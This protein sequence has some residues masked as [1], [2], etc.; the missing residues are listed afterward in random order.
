MADRPNIL[1]LFSDQQ[2]WDTLGCYGQRLPISPNL[3]ALAADGVRFEHAFTCQPVCGPARSCVQ[4]GK[5][6]TQV[7]C[8]ING[9]MLPTDIPTMAKQLNA[10]GYETA[11]I[12]K[13]HLATAPEDHGPDGQT[14]Y[15]HEGVPVER[16]GGYRDYWMASDV[17]EFT[18][19]GFAGYYFDADNQRVDWEGYR[20]DRTADF[21]L[22]YLQQHHERNAEQPDGKPFFCMAS[23]IEPHH[24]ND[25]NRHV[26]P[27]GSKDR[28]ADFDVPGDLVGM[29]EEGYEPGTKPDWPGEYPDYLGCCWSLDQNVGRIVEKLKA[30]GQ[31]ENTLIIYTSDHG[32][33][34]CTRNGEYKRSCH[35]ASI[36]LPMIMH[37]PASMGLRSGQVVDAL[38]SLIDVP[39][40]VLDAAGA[41]PIEG[42][43]GRSMLALTRD[44]AA[45]WPDD[46]FL[47]ISETQ[48]GRAIRTRRW[49]YAVADAD[50]EA[51]GQWKGRA[52]H[53]ERYVEKYLY[54][55]DADPH[56][57]QNLAADPACALVRA[58][59]ASRLKRRLEMAGEPAAEIVP[60]R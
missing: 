59:L 44:E 9:K 25:E 45:D 7:D 60:A 30:L 43:A 32:S 29:E 22:D 26:G 34:F 37:G 17:L 55:L 50:D 28:F 11:Y 13:W 46:V 1:F 12:G 21:V 48:T 42:Q 47:Q 58:E 16:R 27:E 3:D 20:V 6:A 56:E 24:Q 38:V 33:H 39:A 57:R 19:K 2:R 54:D 31:F 18:S 40:T 5:W 53:A 23:F 52:P 4:S 8:H 51:F 41:D 14:K 15:V 35:E 36:R 49:K 10:A